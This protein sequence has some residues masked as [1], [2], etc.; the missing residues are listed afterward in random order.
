MYF[1]RTTDMLGELPGRLSFNLLKGRD[2]PIMSVAKRLKSSRSGFDRALLFDLCTPV[3][4]IDLMALVSEFAPGESPVA[5]RPLS[6][7]VSAQN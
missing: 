3:D 4:E 2:V 5:N 7:Q 6:A 1:L